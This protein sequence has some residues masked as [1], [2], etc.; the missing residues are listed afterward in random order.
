[1]KKMTNVTATAAAAAEAAAAAMM[2]VLSDES[3]GL[4]VVVVVVLVVVLLTVV[5]A[6]VETVL[7][8]PVGGVPSVRSAVF[9]EL[10][11]RVPVLAVV[12]EVSDAGLDMDVLTEVPVVRIPVEAAAVVVTPVTLTPNF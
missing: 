5:S 1:M 3:G 4:L 11:A 7:I 8:A 9:D 12:V 6:N 10:L 2:T